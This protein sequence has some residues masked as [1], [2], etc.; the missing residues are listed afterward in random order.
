MAPEILPQGAIEAES[1]QTIG[2]STNAPPGETQPQRGHQ[3]VH[4]D[5]AIVATKNMTDDTHLKLV[6]KTGSSRSKKQQAIE[7]ES[8]HIDVDHIN[9]EYNT[10]LRYIESYVTNASL[11]V[12]GN[13]HGRPSHLSAQSAKMDITMLSV[14]GCL[15][16]NL[17]TNVPGDGRNRIWRP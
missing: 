17:V 15:Q 9:W 13:L 10:Q 16:T 8:I 7:C 5:A 3:L 11:R 2:A 4:R 12:T 6:C 1:S 14:L